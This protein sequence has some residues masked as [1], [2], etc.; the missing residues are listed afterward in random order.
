M[1]VSC[2]HQNKLPFNFR[3]I[4]CQVVALWKAKIKESFKLLRNA[5]F[6]Y[7]PKQVTIHFSLHYLSS[8]PL[9]ESKNK[10]KIQFFSSKVV[11]VAYE[12]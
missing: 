9:T 8:G 10:G 6:M 12:G 5:R 1:P 3:S 2:T 4:I 11:T 7:S